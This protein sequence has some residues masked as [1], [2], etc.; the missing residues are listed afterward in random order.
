ME[1][2]MEFVIGLALI[3]CMVLAMV[4]RLAF[5]TEWYRRFWPFTEI[6]YLTHQV[7]S[8]STWIDSRERVIED[9]RSELAQAEHLWQ[10]EKNHRALVQIALDSALSDARLEAARADEAEALTGLQH[11]KAMKRTAP[12]K[13]VTKKKTQ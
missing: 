4:A 3:G 6:G 7:E 13:A 5:T 10:S 8:L 12:K 1:I 9:L 2:G 11:A